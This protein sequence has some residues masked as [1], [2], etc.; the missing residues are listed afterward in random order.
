M[1]PPPSDG[2]HLPIELSE[3]RYA[4]AGGVSLAYQT[5][6]GGPDLVVVPGLMGHLEAIWELPGLARAYKELSHAFRVVVFDKRGTGLSDRVPH[7]RGVGLEERGRDIEAVMD[8]AGMDA[9]VL[10]AQADGVPASC[11]FAASHPERVTHLAIYAGSARMLAAEDYEVGLPPEFA[12]LAL[13]QIETRWGDATEPA[14]IELLSPSRAGDASWRRTLARAQRLSCTPAAARAHWQATFEL[15][16]RGILD[17]I[18]APTLA[19]HSAR[20][21]VYPVAQGRW[22]A[23]HI[24][25]AKFVELDHVDHLSPGAFVPEVVE[26]VRGDRSVVTETALMTIL[27][28]DIVGSTSAAA[29]LGDGEWRIVLDRHD[30]MTRRQLV[31]HGGREVKR[32]GDGFLCTFS[33]P[34]AAI[35]AASA[36]RDG[37]KALGMEVRGG[38]HTG[39]VELREDDI[40]GAAVNLA[41]RIQAEAQPSEILVSRT[42]RDLLVGSAFRFADRGAHELKGVPESWQLYGVA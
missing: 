37:A 4:D 38:V 35:E 32:T 42:V 31:R 26:F 6:G 11:A 8:A 33:G 1:S 15:D 34:A 40:A 18:R 25:N 7:D 17:A 21:L 30:A 20:D 28:T 14:A 3:I 12:E 41:A 22:L 9:A 10:I 23:D 36:I 24:A 13:S 19:V 2:E 39:T 5:F 29:E 16:I 27:F